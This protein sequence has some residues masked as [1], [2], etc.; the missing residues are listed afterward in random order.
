VIKAR[1]DEFFESVA[2]GSTQKFNV[3]SSV[4]SIV[5]VPLSL[6]LPAVQQE[7][8]SSDLQDANERL[9]LSPSGED[10][11][12]KSTSDDSSADDEDVELVQ[13][14]SDDSDMN[15]AV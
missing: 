10:S 12:V 11:D 15:A 5:I 7:V 13:V 9:R 6:E 3:E 4:S 2:G 14:E 1:S 8:V